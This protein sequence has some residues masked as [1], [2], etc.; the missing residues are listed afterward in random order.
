MAVT[1][2]LVIDDSITMRALFTNA[3]ERSKDIVVVGAVDSADEARA[4]IPKLQP[5]VLT[6]DVEMPGMNGLDFLAELMEKQ[7][8]PVVMLSTLT[9]KG[10][11]VSLRAIELGAV[12][13]FPKPQRATP[14]EFEKI[15]GKLCKVV[16]TAA[17][18]NLAA[19]KVPAATAPAAALG[20]Y[21]W[22]GEIIA[23]AGGMG[24]IE[25]ASDMLVAFPANCPPTIVS[26]A[27]DEG[28]GVPF[29]SR[30]SK[31]TSAKVKLAA[32]GESLEPGTM[33]IAVDPRFH[34][35]VDRWPGGRLR[36]VER[37][38][39]NG[40]RPSADLL[41]GSV[42][43][44]GGTKAIGVVLSGDGNDGAAGIAAIKSA[45]G[46]CLVQDPATALVPCM[47]QAAIARGVTATA[48]PIQ[49]AAYACPTRSPSLAA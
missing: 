29:A 10:A 46:I 14:D 32:D 45:G 3:L 5:N 13:C 7:P 1:K 34:V 42:A 18:T 2:V 49:L 8:I 27:I 16:L 6:L 40:V 19:R 44:T 24:A 12:D 43:K 37:D 17:K 33:Y 31:N 47:A 4:M 26:L 25:A 9:Q 41:F 15:S 11:D 30:L 20:D 39:V 28:L 22:D 38:P 35:V 23:V 36:L 21:V 48:A